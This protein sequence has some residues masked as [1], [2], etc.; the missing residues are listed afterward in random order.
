MTSYLM[1]W[2]PDLVTWEPDLMT[3]EPDLMTQEPD[4]MTWEPDLMTQEPDLMT[5]EPDLMTWEPDIMPWEPDDFSN[6]CIR[7]QWHHIN[8]S[9]GMCLVGVPIMGWVKKCWIQLLKL[10]EE[11]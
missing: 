8:I 4:L 5:W 3:W 10:Y 7:C 1:T 6:V 11:Q 2:E 9:I